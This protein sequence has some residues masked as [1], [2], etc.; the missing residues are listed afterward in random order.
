MTTSERSRAQ[1]GARP[2]AG[3]GTRNLA[4]PRGRRCCRRLPAALIAVGGVCALSACGTGRVSRTQRAAEPAVSPQPTVRPAGQLVHVGGM[5]EGIVADPRTDL[6]AVGLREPP[7]LAL[8]DGSTG[9][10]LR[11]VSIPGA[12]RHLQLAGPGGPVLVPAETANEL[13]QVTLPGGRVSETPTLR[14]PHDA[15]EVAGRIFV[16]NE[17]GGSVSVISEQRTVAQLSGLLQ[18]GG[19]A[20]DGEKVAVIDVRSDLLS[21]YDART[22]RLLGR[23]PAGSGPTH[24]VAGGGRLYVADTRG[25]AIEEFDTA[26][27]LHR[28]SRLALPGTPYGL[29]IDPARQRLW[30]TLT[31]RN[32]L[33]ELALGEGRLRPIMRYPTARQPNT[34]AIDVRSGHVFVADRTA[35][36]VQIIDPTG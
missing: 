8:I 22:L 36:E 3:A 10:V 34:V 23:V 18:P 6:V 32:E 1:G 7:I 31:A 15:A 16:G 30:V 11:R 19:I 5:P 29:A 4:R 35:G 20:A 12:P 17:Y 26:G 24:V 33:V 27:G 9:S 14:Q 25:S 28:L 21:L 13:V 2:C